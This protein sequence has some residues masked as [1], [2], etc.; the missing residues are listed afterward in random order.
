[1]KKIALLVQTITTFS[2]ILISTSCSTNDHVHTMV[3]DEA[4]EPTCTETG[5][6]QGIHCSDCGEIIIKQY[7]VPALGHSLITSDGKQA[8]CE[9]AG[10]TDKVL[11]ERCDLVLVE[12]ED[13]KAIG[14]D[15]DYDHAIFQWKKDDDGYKSVATVHCM[16]DG[17]H[18]LKLD[19]D[20][21][22]V[23]K[24]EPTFDSD[25]VI[26]YTAT[27]SA[28]GVKYKDS[29]EEKLDK[30]ECLHK[31]AKSYTCF[32]HD[33]YEDFT[34]EEYCNICSHK[35]SSFNINNG[36]PVVYVD[37]D[38]VP[39]LNK[40][41]DIPGTMKIVDVDSSISSYDLTIKGR[42][43]ATWSYPKKPYKFKLASKQKILGMNKNKSWA[44]LASYTD[45]TLLRN[46]IGF[47]ASEIFGLSYTPDYRFVEL[48]LNGEYLGN[49]ML[50]ETVK[51]GS[52]RVDVTDNG[53][54]VE[55]FLNQGEKDVKFITDSG[56]HLFDFKFPD[57]DELTTEQ[58]NYAKDTINALE[59]LLYSEGDTKFSVSEGYRNYIDVHEWAKWFL[60]QN[61]IANLD[62]NK[63]FYKYDN[64]TSSKIMIGPMWDFEWSVGIG[65]YYGERPNPN[66]E[67]LDYIYFDI[68]L[69]DPYFK[70]IL[71]EEW[72]L[73]KDDINNELMNFINEQAM[74]LSVS[75]MTNF[76]VWDIMNK[77]ISIGGVPM[78]S[79]WAEVNCD[80]EYL[81]A[82]IN[83]INNLIDSWRI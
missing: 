80:K 37:T 51:E 27:I 19:A 72:D 54:I 78:G 2:L 77:N 83:W 35:I 16:H 13:I 52:N 15:Y 48:V 22:S 71:I 41:D 55:T 46:A 76:T 40:I 30:K 70:S 50:T 5:L 75:Q 8:T 17:S 12:Q 25:G 42:G 11:C 36:C 74:A 20:V 61:V 39:I 1:M 10:K 43:N 69:E 82:H 6:T 34:V 59:D 4:V 56:G 57:D 28:G 18:F 68:L 66:H 64:T 32:D 26:E 67:L 14:H 53:F 31:G 38:N 23:I 81:S 73:V 58:L 65:W 79:Y 9:V 24:K 49:Y 7:V 3:V 44:L 47:K 60:A 63:Y 45:K 33:S 29:F 62:T 21:N